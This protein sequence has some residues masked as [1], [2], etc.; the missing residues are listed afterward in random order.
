MDEVKHRVLDFYSAYYDAH[1]NILNQSSWGAAEMPLALR[2]KYRTVQLIETDDGFVIRHFDNPQNPWFP[3]N[4][5]EVYQVYPRFYGTTLATYTG[6]TYE[7]DKH[8]FEVQF[9]EEGVLGPQNAERQDAVTRIR[10]EHLTTE[11]AETLALE[12]LVPF[13]D[14][15][16]EQPESE[17]G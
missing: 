9:F 8:F 2:P 4:E 5:N 17:E 1:R 11:E 3:G 7:P 16:R 15:P 13:A 12:H 6:L 14:I 10:A